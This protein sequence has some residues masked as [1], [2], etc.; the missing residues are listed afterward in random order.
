MSHT[1]GLEES[2]DIYF[3]Y[4]RWS[5]PQPFSVWCRLGY[6]NGIYT[7]SISFIL[8]YHCF[9]TII[10]D[11]KNQHNSNSRIISGDKMKL[12]VAAE[13]DSSGSG[14]QSNM[15]KAHGKYIIL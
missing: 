3:D 9:R 6:S 14:R 13:S 5:L 1:P 7:S 2:E 4:S 15:H 8:C 10:D 12:T 11:T